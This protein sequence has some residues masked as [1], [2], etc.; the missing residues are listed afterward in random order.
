MRLLVVCD[1]GKNRSV[2]LADQLKYM[3]HDVL[4]AGLEVNHLDTLS[5]L[6]AWA[7][8]VILTDREQA[9]Q[10][11]H[12][13]HATRYS[14]WHIGADIYPRAYNRDLL[15]LCKRLIKEHQHE[16]V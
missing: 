3:G 7:D 2:T 12:F 6:A 11:E 8:L 15:V 10:L 9:T 14:V 16:L 1:H 4:T 13:N 5:Y